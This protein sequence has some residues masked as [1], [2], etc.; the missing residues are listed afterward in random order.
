MTIQIVFDKPG[1]YLINFQAIDRKMILNQPIY[2]GVDTPLLPDYLDYY[3][4]FYEN[5]FENAT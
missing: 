4:Y 1:S 3:E 2:V 5:N